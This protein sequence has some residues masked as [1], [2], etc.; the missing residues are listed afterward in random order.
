[1]GLPGTPHRVAALFRSTP[2]G[3]R[4]GSAGQ[5]REDREWRRVGDGRKLRGYKRK[6]PGCLGW[7]YFFEGERVP[8][9]EASA[10]GGRKTDGYYDHCRAVYGDWRRDRLLS[11]GGRPPLGAHSG[12]GHD[13]GYP[14]HFRSGDHYYFLRPVAQSSEA[15]QNHPLR[16]E[17]RSAAVDRLY[18]HTITKIAQKRP[19]K[20]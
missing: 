14:R 3:T 1:R 11:H 15:L 18:L 17:A 4:Q 12:A 8:E 10:L 7:L 13:P 6:R 16:K 5:P 20:P 19:V 9:D 2:K